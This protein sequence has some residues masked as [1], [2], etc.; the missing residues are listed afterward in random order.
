MIREALRWLAAE[1]WE[2]INVVETWRSMRALGRKY[3][4]RFLVAAV[5]W[6]VFEDVVCPYLAWKAGAAWLIPVFLVMH[7]EFLAYPVFL[8]LFRTY[9]RLR[10]REPWEPDRLVQSTYWRSGLQVLSYRVPALV[11]FY[12]ILQNLG[13]SFWVLA[14]HTVGMTLFGLVHERLWHDSNFGIDVPTDTVEPKRVLIK[15]STYRA[16]SVLMMASVF[17]GVL[18][19]VPW[20]DLAAYQGAAWILHLVVLGLWAQSP[21]GLRAVAARERGSH[22]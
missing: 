11:L 8:F 1:A 20:L 22:D 9:D 15:A 17:F 21:M 12:L 5:L 6:E 7:F 16:V 13:V 14:A 2:K 3:G 10:G 18:G 19:Q 4:P